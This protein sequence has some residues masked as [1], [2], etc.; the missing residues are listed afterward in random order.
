[1]KWVMTLV[2][3]T[4]SEKRGQRKVL[5]NYQHDM[6]KGVKKETIYFYF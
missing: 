5:Q 3:K 1:M 2:E 4:Y 6:G